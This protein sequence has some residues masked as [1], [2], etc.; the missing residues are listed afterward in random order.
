MHNKNRLSLFS[1]DGSFHGSDVRHLR[2]GVTHDDRLPPGKPTERLPVGVPQMSPYRRPHTIRRSVRRPSLPQMVFCLLSR[3]LAS[4]LFE[5][6]P[7]LFE[8]SKTLHVVSLRP[9]TVLGTEKLI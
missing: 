4:P 9:E 5:I 1:D 7:V 8:R 3:I 2:P 6:V